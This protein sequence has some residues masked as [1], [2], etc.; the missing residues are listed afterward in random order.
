MACVS[1]TIAT[2]LMATGNEPTLRFAAVLQRLWIDVTLLAS[3]LIGF[4]SS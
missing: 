1:A 4:G 2:L 3:T